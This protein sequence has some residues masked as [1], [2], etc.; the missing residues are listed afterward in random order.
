M[1]TGIRAMIDAAVWLED[2]F[3]METIALGRSAV[4]DA[5]SALEIGGAWLLFR[6]ALH[7]PE[8]RTAAC[9][10]DAADPPQTLLRT[11]DT[12]AGS[13][14]LNATRSEAYRGRLK[15]ANPASTGMRG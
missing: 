3:G 9:L 13:Q 15:A 1:S 8:V 2:Q 5:D 6:L 10:M 7:G 12:E 14:A 11:P 4:D